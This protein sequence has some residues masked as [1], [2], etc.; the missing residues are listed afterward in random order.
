M[1]HRSTGSERQHSRE[2]LAFFFCVKG[3]QRLPIS[4]SDLR[5]AD[6]A[7]VQVASN[8]APKTYRAVSCP[9]RLLPYHSMASTRANDP[10][11]NSNNGHVLPFQ[12]LLFH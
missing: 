10:T 4:R 1:K 7:F 12:S 3:N 9:A 5:Q 8:P 2:V 11:V 6:A